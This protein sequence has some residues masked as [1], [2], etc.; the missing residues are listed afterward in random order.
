[1]NARYRIETGRLLKFLVAIGIA[2]VPAMLGLLLLSVD[3]A[4]MPASYLIG[5]AGGAAACALVMT[6]TIH[7]RQAPVIGDSSTWA[8]GGAAPA[9]SQVANPLGNFA[10]RWAM[11]EDLMCVLS[12]RDWSGKTVGEFGGTNEVIHTCMRGAQYRLFAY[13]EYDLQDL[14][15]VPDAILDVA[16]LDQVLEHVP[17]PEH[18]L[19]E[20][21]RV[22]RPS[23][24]A[25]VTTPFLLPVHTTETYGDYYRWTPQGMAT[26]LQ[27]TGFSSQVR[28]W[29]NRVAAAAM[30][31]DM[32][33]TA[34]QAMDRKLGISMG[35]SE[36]DY[37]VTVWALAEK[38][39]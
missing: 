9:W 14:K 23:G 39:A 7:R 5:L 8:A 12:T 25:I 35:E 26:M 10:A 1:M 38:K 21:R 34:Q 18:A 17:D 3:P 37:P 2:W 19:R 36:K 6:R 30:F 16:V 11:Y 20:I 13:P 33:M 31:E 22:L 15:N 4:L 27:R 24:L 29:G 32:Y 28:M